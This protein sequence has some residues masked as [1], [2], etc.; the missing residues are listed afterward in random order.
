MLAFNGIL[1]AFVASV[2]SPSVLR[3]Q[4]AVMLLF[5][6]AYAGAG[7][8]LLKMWDR[9][10]VGLVWA[11]GIAMAARVG[12][13]TSFVRGWFDGQGLRVELEGFA[14]RWTTVAWSFGVKV[15]LEALKMG[16]DGS[17]WDLGKTIATGGFYGLVL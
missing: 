7:V 17:L 14:P 9:G 12:F 1:E 6:A 15:V 16:F 3:A 13:S 11:N 10:A 5:S 8:L 4:A 2:A